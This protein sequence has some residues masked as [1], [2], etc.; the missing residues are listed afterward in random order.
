MTDA[1]HGVGGRDR[2]SWGGRRVLITGGAGVVGS[3]IADQ[4]AE[5][6]AAEI[7]VLDNFSR[8][9]RSNLEAAA[10]RGRVTIV[11]ADLRDRRVVGEAM[12]G[13]D[14]VFHQ[15]AIRL[16]Q[17]VEDPR[18]GLEVMVDGTFNVLEA[19]VQAG[20]RK[21]VA[22]SSA[23]IYGTAEHVPIDERHHPYSDRTLYGAA[24]L[25]SEGLLRS[26]HDTHGLDYVALRYFNVY[27]PRMDL[28][29]AYTEV[30]V[31]WIARIADGQAPIIFGDGSPTLDLVHVTDVAA[32]NL[33]AAQSTVTDDSF[34][35]GSGSEISLCQLASTLLAIMG[36]P[37]HP[38]HAPERAVYTVPR[39]LADVSKAQ[40]LLDYRP[41]VS[42]AEGLAGLVAWWRETSRQA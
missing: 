29:G 6:G 36:S 20:V 38:E 2:P 31:R 26:F 25:F 33:L 9:R 18:L 5:A 19:A 40:R 17:C 21:L 8:G 12:R 22:A 32:A 16:T 23:S 7:V 27:G 10:A 41:R 28:T 11:E 3:H 42:L 39:R 1:R 37:L 15:A 4:V 13:I 14:V 34:N 35:I 24:K 30:L